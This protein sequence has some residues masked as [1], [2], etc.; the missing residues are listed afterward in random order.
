MFVDAVKELV[1]FL[2]SFLSVG[3]IGFRFAI[4]RRHDDEIVWRAARR[5]AV[6]GLTGVLVT[7]GMLFFVSLPEVAARKHITVLHAITGNQ[8]TALQVGGWLFAALLFAAAAADWRWT[9]PFAAVG[10]IAGSL[11]PLFFGQVTRAINPIHRFAAG[12]WIGT[13]FVVVVAGLNSVLRSSGDKV[14]RG[15][16]AADLINTFS[17]LALGSFFVLASSGVWTAWRHLKH[18]DA[19]WTT[20]YGYALIAKLI[21]VAIVVA[22]G[23]FNWRRQRPLLGSESA[24]TVLRRS[25]TWELAAAGAVLLI[26]AVLV[27]LP[28]PR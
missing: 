24:A 2:A 3:A 21:V 20:S 13:L 22:L 18:I 1:G 6:L 8:M 9:W 16:I 14:E 23:A 28:S 5:A 26:T 7:L 4:R 15:R 27:S 17:P 12:M 19:L 11:T 25:A 10:V